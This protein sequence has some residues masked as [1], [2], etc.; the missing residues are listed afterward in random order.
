P[1]L[2]VLARAHFRS[3]AYDLIEAGADGV[4]RESLDTALRAGVDIMRQLGFRA[5]QAHRA[6]QSFRRQDER[7]VVELASVRGDHETYLTRA[8]ESI[9]DLE[10]NLSAEARRGEL[11]DDAAWDPDTLRAEYGEAEPK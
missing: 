4:Y 5:H 11:P 2:K 8:R 10:R 3:E 7:A 6:A 1:K 9:R